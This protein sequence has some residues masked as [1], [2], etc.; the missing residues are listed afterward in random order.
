VFYYSVN[1]ESEAVYLDEITAAAKKY[2]RLHAHITDSSRDGFLTADTT[3][4][5][6]PDHSAVWVYMCGPRGMMSSMA[7]QFEHLG[8][9]ASRVRWEQF[10]VRR[11]QLRFSE[12]LAVADSQRQLR[13][14][15][16]ALG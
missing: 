11:G 16:P 5:G 13:N 15:R 9:P 1:H 2:P 12:E 4:S 14:Q 8:I 3:I 7:K 10:N 6:M